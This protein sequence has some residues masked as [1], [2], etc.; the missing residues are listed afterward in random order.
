MTPAF[1][2]KA[3]V[4]AVIVLGIVWQSFPLK[5]AS[6]RLSTIPL[7]GHGFAGANVA[8]DSEE[9]SVYGN[10][11]VLK[12]KYVCKAG[13]VLVTL[14]DGTHNRHGVHDPIY[15]LRGAGWQIIDTQSVAAPRGEGAWVRAT[16]DGKVSELTYWFSEPDQDYPNPT[17]YWLRTAL[18]HMSL[19]ASGQEP[20]LV[21]V[22][23]IGGDPI[24]MTQLY[25]T[26]P[27][28]QKL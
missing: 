11:D 6:S 16:R 1:A 20:V 14:V 17:K 24:D 15:C 23:P 21:I 26:L 8:L 9:R 25:R 18:R 5:D 22:E 19:G 27:P 7:T 28:V 2:L 4:P 13:A 10:A 3:A 12:R